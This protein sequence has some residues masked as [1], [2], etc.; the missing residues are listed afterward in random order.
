M[1]AGARTSLSFAA[2]S[3]AARALPPRADEPV[4][5]AVAA[6]TAFL[7]PERE[8]AACANTAFLFPEHGERE[9]RRLG[10]ASER[11][12]AR[13]VLDYLRHA[14]S[15]T[16]T[17]AARVRFAPPAEVTRALAGGRG[18]V[19]CTAHLGNWELGA[20]MLARL[21]RPVVIVAGPQYLAPWRAGV[22]RAK[23]SAGIRVLSERDSA[24]PLMRTLATGGI[25]GLL[26][27]G[28]GYAGGLPV[29]LG[30]GRATLP[31]IPAELAARTGAVLAGGLCRRVAPGRFEAGLTPLGGSETAPVRE[32]GPL[33]EAMAGWLEDVLR[34]HP[35]EW[36]IF[37][38]FFAGPATPLA[39]PEPR[40][41]GAR[42][43]CV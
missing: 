42:V 31:T 32:A 19:V 5:L 20:L 37:R 12:Y 3:W 39:G 2:L 25:V 33:F 16:E 18:L 34:S 36:C 17:L 43:E 13:F 30:S 21:G 15:S 8:R 26:I 10:R 4:A 35:G 40:V 41:V 9:R 6:V 11:A 38:P 24:T 28:A 29:R 7:R 1:D 22:R 27:D 23:E 14:R